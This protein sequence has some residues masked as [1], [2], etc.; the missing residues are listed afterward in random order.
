MPAGSAGM[1]SEPPIWS[2]RPQ[3]DVRL[4]DL[5]LDEGLRGVLFRRPLQLAIVRGAQSAETPA[6]NAAH[7][8]SSYESA[9][10]CSVMKSPMGV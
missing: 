9:G 10:R 5:G 3:E 6:G 8:V 1:R 7:L 4:P 2:A